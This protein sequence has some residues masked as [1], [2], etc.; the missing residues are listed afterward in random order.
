[1]KGAQLPLAVQ[2][3]E[4]ASFASFHAGPN[5]AAVA[6][7]RSGSENVFLY[8]PAAS[9]KSHLLQ[10]AA[11]EWQAAYLPLAQFAPLG[12]EALEGYSDARA[13]CV[14]EADAALAQREW[15]I[16]LLRLLDALRTRGAR[17]AVAAGAAPERLGIALPD[18][19]T[20]LAACAVFGLQPLDDSDRAA[21]LRERAQARG[22]QMPEEVARWLLS[23]LPR[24]SA[25]L[26]DVLERLDR[27]SLAHQRR[28]TLPFV[29]QVTLP[30]LQ[31]ELPLAP[32]PA[33]ARTGSGSG[34]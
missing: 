24:D 22:L 10:A 14:D 28:L 23:Q 31:A 33:G 26:I 15:C 30:L 16:A 20:R 32:A 25:S 5:A 34:S 21:L 12:P 3:R 7:L 9:G 18:L 27:A 4:S 29:Q 19:R 11:R 17:C 2:L 8:G 1:M 6:A 13:L